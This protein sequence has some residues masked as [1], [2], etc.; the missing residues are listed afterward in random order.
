[1]HDYIRYSIVL[2]ELEKICNPFLAL[3]QL[4]SSE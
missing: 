1:M 3:L 2:I 4:R